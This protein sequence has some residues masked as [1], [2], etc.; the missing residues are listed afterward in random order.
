MENLLSQPIF[1][2]VVAQ[3]SMGTFIAK[4]F[5]IALAVFLGARYLSGITAGDYVQILVIG[6]FIAVLNVTIGSLLDFIT[7]PLRWITLG[8]FALVVD[9]IIIMIAD[10]F[11][12]T[13][14][15][16]SFV[17]ALL[18]AVIIALTNALLG[19]VFM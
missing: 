19:P 17:W 9:A 18:L 6:L 10:Y 4:T 16:K 14:K 7:A 5:I 12:D 3:A 13:F 11:L 15:V 8:L 2:D 1:L